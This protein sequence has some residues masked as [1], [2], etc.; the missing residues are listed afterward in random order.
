MGN[1][2]APP[3]PPL[4]RVCAPGEQH[5]QCCGEGAT[6]EGKLAGAGLVVHVS[7]EGAGGHHGGAQH[8]LPLLPQ[9]PPQLLLQLI[10]THG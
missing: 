7:V 3:L 5:Q 9:Q 2:R 6:E 1:A 4:R 8:Y 10:C